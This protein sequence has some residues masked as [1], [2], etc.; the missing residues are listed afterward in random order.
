MTG[1]VGD[2]S[3]YIDE[4]GYESY[5]RENVAAYCSLFGGEPLPGVLALSSGFM[6]YEGDIHPKYASV[7][8][9]VVRSPTTFVLLPSLDPGP[10]VAET[11]RRQVGRP[12]RRSA[13]KEEA[14]IRT[15]FPIYRELPIQKVKTMRPPDVIADE[16]VA[17]LKPVLSDRS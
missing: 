16:I 2:I 1:R 7:R 11:V 5:A 13:A 3:E 8:A 14:V 4:H 6:T 9:E 15:R 12:F 10:C 17:I